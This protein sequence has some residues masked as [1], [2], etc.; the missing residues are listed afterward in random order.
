MTPST[1]RSL[2]ESP[3]SLDES[4]WQKLMVGCALAVAF[5]PI[6]LFEFPLVQQI[7]V[8]LPLCYFALAFL[9]RPLAPLQS[10]IATLLCILFIYAAPGILYNKLTQDTG[11]F[12]AIVL[13]LLPISAAYV[14]D[15]K[16]SVDV[17]RLLIQAQWIGLAYFLGSLLRLAQDPN[18]ELLWYGIHERSFLLGFMVVP[19]LL[20]RSYWSFFL[21]TAAAC[22]LLALD[23][24]ATTAFCLV[25][26]IFLS[27]LLIRRVPTI[28]IIIYVSV[29]LIC[30]I[31]AYV[32][33]DIIWELYALVKGSYSNNINDEVR[34]A[35]ITLAYDEWAKA[36]IFGDFFSGAGA[37]DIKPYVKWWQGGLI[38][39][40]ND[41]L[42]FL[43]RGGVVGISM[44]II[45]LSTMFVFF[46]RNI[47][48]FS[49]PSLSSLRLLNTFLFVNVVNIV[50]VISFNAILKTVSDAFIVQLVFGWTVAL[51]I[52]ANYRISVPAA[53]NTGSATTHL[54]AQDAHI[55]M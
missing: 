6:K 27:M 22:F 1:T 37:Y 49:A 44:F 21:T 47:S 48:R 20:M 42:D 26:S 31:S 34:R 16:M 24:R 10:V 8:A 45:L 35:A 14:V 25:N 39:L 28:F 30:L 7:P 18:G 38:P 43:I 33:Y 50:F 36:P 3:N 4:L 51:Q 5:D 54:K 23:F 17:K 52:F 40:H 29:I 19:S 53:L 32:G 55:L 46:I 13:L 41:Y 12:T 9:R 11:M 2:P 15:A